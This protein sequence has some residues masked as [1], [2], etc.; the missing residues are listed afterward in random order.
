[1][2]IPVLAA[3]AASPSISDTEKLN[4]GVSVAM[5]AREGIYEQARVL[6][7]RSALIDTGHGASQ[8]K[9]YT[10]EIRSGI[11]SGKSRI[12]TSDI[13]NNPFQIDPRVGDK[14]I[15]YFVPDTNGGEPQAYLESF[16]R[17][18]AI[19]AL[20]ILFVLTLILLAGWQGFK[21]AVSILASVLI[22]G[23]VL[24]PAFLKGVNPVPIALIL[25]GVLTGIA[26]ILSTAWNKKTVVTI[27]GTVGG[28]LMAYVVGS[29][30]SGWAHLSGL[31][32]DEDRLFFTK[33]P[34]LNP[35]GLLF[36]GIIIASLGVVMDV[37]V[38][39]ASGIMEVQQANPKL[40]F[41]ALFRS[42]MVVGRDH[43]AA[44]ANTL[45]FAYVGGSLSTLLLYTQYGGSWIKFLNFDGIVDEIIRSLSGTIG[46]TFTVPI[47]ALLGAWLMRGRTHRHLD[48]TS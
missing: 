11:Y 6:D 42:G 2:P 30:F 27:I 23:F 39:I 43:M 31:A 46:L 17:R 21:V 20:I 16:D 24:I 29:A 41:K 3:A 15:V 48:R 37:A 28:V 26:S 32:T 19:Y 10:V 22:I 33:N 12:L 9:K 18:G 4:E 25:A 36:S 45:V 5:S 14:I 13:A 7:V 44:L 8:V 47:T 38:S 1:M 35:Q 40:G 34:L